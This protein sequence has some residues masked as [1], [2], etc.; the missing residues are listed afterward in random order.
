[1]SIKEIA[2]VGD[3][4]RRI[5]ADTAQGKQSSMIQMDMKKWAQKEGL[6]PQ[7]NY[8]RIIEAHAEDRGWMQ[9]DFT[10]LEIIE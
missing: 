5:Y 9:E 3:E 6:W 1:M 4:V 10:G 8:H 7:V 2:F